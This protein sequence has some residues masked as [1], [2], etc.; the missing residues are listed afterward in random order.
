MIAAHVRYLAFQCS[1]IVRT[2]AIWKLSY[3][4]GDDDRAANGVFAS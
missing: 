3:D 2:G 1:A 4:I